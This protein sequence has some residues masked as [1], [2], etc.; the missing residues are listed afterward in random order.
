MTETAPDAFARALAAQA[1]AARPDRSA[2]VEAHAGS[3]KTKVLIDRVARL[4]LRREDGRK[5][6]DPD[7]ILCVTYTKAAANE[8]LSRLFGQLGRWSVLEDTELRAELARLEHRAPES[9][10]QEDLKAARALFARALET[11]GGLRIETIHAFCSRIL[12]RFPLEADVSP[13][14]AEMEDQEADRLWD[15]SL[16]DGIVTA[17]KA[18]PDALEILSEA[19]GGFGAAAP[20]S[21]LR[22]ARGGLTGQDPD[23][24]KTQLRARLEAP[25]ETV[26]EIME[27]AVGRGLPRA[28][29]ASIAQGLGE[30]DKPGKSDGNLL[31]TLVFIL[32]DAPLMERWDVYRTIFLTTTGAFRASNPYTAGAAKT[33]PGLA[34]LFQMKDGEGSEAAR[35]RALLKD[36]IARQAYERTVALIDTGLPVLSAFRAGKTGR[37]ALDFD[38]LI[39]HTRALL[40]SGGLAEWVLYKLDGGLTH[41]LLDEAQDTSPA[42]WEIINAL[43]SEFRAGEG[44]E[45]S[46]DPRTQFT[47]GDKKQSIYSFQ[48]A[49][50]EQFLTEKRRFAEAEEALHGQANLPDMTMSFRSSPEVLSFVD[51]VF[52]QD[53]FEGHPFSETIPDEADDLTHVARRADQ[54]G[55]VDLWPV[56]PHTDEEEGDPWD[57]PLD[58]LSE[59]SPRNR[60]AQKVAAE[61]RQMIDTGEPVW[62]NGEQKAA[63]PDDILILVRKRGVLFEA[64][65]KA[66]KAAKLPVAGADR[67]VLLD[68]IGVQDCLNLI[69]FAL[70][71]G[72]DL[73]LAEILR[74]PFCGLVDD[75]NELFPLA[76]GRSKDERLWDRLKTATDPRF[77][78]ARAFCEDLLA[79][80]HLSAFDLIMRVLVT[81]RDG[82]S[83]WDRLIQRLGEPARDPVNALINRALGHAMGEAASLQTFLAEIEG[84]D[85]QLKR[86]LA[87]AHGQIRVMTVHGAKGLQAP[88]V[89]L[90][91]T[92]GGEKADTS[93]LFML[94]DGTPVYSPRKA[95]DPPLIAELREAR[96]AAQAR[97]A[98]RLLYV[99]LTRAQ[100]RLVIGGAFTGRKTSAGYSEGS[101]YALCRTA[102]LELTGTDE[103]DTSLTYGNIVPPVGKAGDRRARP[104]APGWTRTPVTRHD[105]APRVTAPSRLL[106][107]TAPVTKPFGKA[108]SA[109]LK[110]GQLI[111]ALLQYLPE[112]PEDTRETAARSWL[113]RHTD[114]EASARA[115]ILSVT[116]ATLNDPAFAAVFAPGGRAEAAVVG[117]LTSGGERLII[118]G[119]VDRLVINETDILLI[120][121]KTDRPAPARAEDIDSSYLLQ[122]AAYQMVLETAWE[123][124]TVRPALLYTDGP[125]LFELAP[126]L[127]ENS[128]NRLVDGV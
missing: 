92:T 126:S 32:S 78:A 102:M 1:L 35:F 125:K 100:D 128:R 36:L 15:E 24:L 41:I 54:P 65:I 124:R 59:S 64:I 107:D 74:G 16:A 109:A 46:T 52:N 115:E 76:H 103:I 44:A 10:S 94:E 88:I 2:W 4:L 80:R 14:F 101:W 13:G 116:L 90:P 81:R 30:L 118:N 29:L 108:R 34:D 83:G 104:E 69:R 3:G 55:R 96:A 113:D 111:H 86:D 9:Y 99:A 97:E 68:H 91:D 42:Q 67:L 38:D 117:E 120:D 12:R 72:D 56:E 6:A 71:P 39:Q 26:E 17:S 8:M 23:S 31:E 84:D 82:L 58:H 21:S 70:M 77:T 50:P 93:S 75:D 19:G 89:I 47:V 43:V 98:R 79:N 85:S 112:L 61:I 28:A 106:R 33:T 11:P 53:R 63:E 27:R 7:T 119:R 62:R 20:L 66:L 105:R 48:G 87:E 110:R 60:L 121:F 5:G 45:R 18:R 123:G 22:G 114:L 73:T 127:L 51:N 49:D 40:T 57:A 122:M 25:D 37:A 95:D